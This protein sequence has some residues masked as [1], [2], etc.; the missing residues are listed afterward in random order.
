M[1]QYMKYG[2]YVCITIVL[3]I[4][5]VLWALWGGKNYEFIGLAPLSSET[6]SSYTGSVY[7]WGNTPIEN[8]QPNII[9]DN[10]PF[11]P[12]EFQPPENICPQ[13]I[14]IPESKPQ[15]VAPPSQQS[16]Q[17]QQ[18]KQKQKGKFISKGERT[19][20]QTMERIYGVPFSSKWPEWLRNP[21]TG[22]T[23]ELDCYNDELKLAI[24]YN[25]EQH[26]KWPNF[27]NQTYEQFINQI[28]RDSL[29]VDLC[30]RQGV[31]LISVPYNVPH[32]KIPAYIM[33]YLPETIRKRLQ[34]EKT[35]TNLGN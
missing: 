2:P 3:V 7:S 1:L 10:T 15:T 4:L 26:Y 8:V 5:F 33:S 12:Q 23:L 34:E 20:C 17:A 27:T 14:A 25:G 13:E 28:R 18:S 32:D 29:K 6:C 22:R 9:V 16:Q 31:Y 11:V 21:E 30:D 35:L 24:E 19:C